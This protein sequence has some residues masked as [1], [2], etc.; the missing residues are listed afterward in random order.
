[1]WL[2]LS[3]TNIFL[4]YLAEKNYEFNKKNCKLFLFL[5]I[6]VN[7]IILGFRDFG[8]GV[9]TLAYI[10]QYFIY[11]SNMLSIKDVFNQDDFDTGFLILAWLSTLVSDDSQSLLFLTELFVIS[12]IMFGIY[13]LKAS[14]NFSITWF[15]LFFVLVY[16]YE[17]INLMRQFCAMA[18]LMLAFSYFLQKK[19]YIY[20]FLQLCAYY[21]HSTSI[22]FVLIP[23]YYYIVSN[24]SNKYFF[25]L[26]LAIGFFFGIYFIIHYYRFL[27]AI[28]NMG[29]FKEE[30]FDRYGLHGQYSAGG[31]SKLNII[32]FIVN[33]TI[34]SYLLKKKY[35]NSQSAYMILVLSCFY[36]IGNLCS[37]IVVYF[38]RISYYFGIIML[39]YLSMIPKLKIRTLYYLNCI[40]IIIFLY[41]ILNVYY[42]S[43]YEIVDNQSDRY[44]LVYKS[45]ILGIK[46]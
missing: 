18:L 33:I 10:D 46:E 39:V 6:V 40:N 37:L 24:Y 34:A 42:K 4:A 30:Y 21:F 31:V 13:R 15:M 16:Q 19:H 12:F 25:S 26:C 28:E 20:V 32:V 41:I 36:F 5:I 29:L 44:H 45:K 9:D 43:Y 2:L 23:L 8:V 7:T 38:I 3:I 35:L 1:M 22:L 17:T 14:L 11:A 27:G